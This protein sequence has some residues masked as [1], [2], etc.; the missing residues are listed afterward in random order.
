MPKRATLRR[1]DLIE[2]QLSYTVVGVLYRVFNEIGPGLHEKYYQ[3]A[4]AAGLR[5][6]G[7][8]FQQ[9]VPIPLKFDGKTI[10]K[11]FADFIIKDRIVLELKRG[12]RINRAHANQLLAYLRA[13]GRPLGIL[14]YFGTDGVFFKRILNEP[15]SNS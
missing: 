10:G 1:N 6:A 14:A 7:V 15:K 11:Y 12:L 13:T 5:D 2:P 8:T 9:E 3:R 4:V